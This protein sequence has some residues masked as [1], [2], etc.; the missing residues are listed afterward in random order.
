MTER[1][2][3]ISESLRYLTSDE[4]AWG[5]FVALAKT[6]SPGLRFSEL[7]ESQQEKPEGE[8]RFVV[9]ADNALDQLQSRGLID[10]EEHSPPRYSL[11]H[12]GL[13]TYGVFSSLLRE[14]ELYQP[15]ESRKEAFE[16]LQEALNEGLEV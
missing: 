13:R 8:I 15:T 4:V 10:R 11:N 14:I 1:K 9:K 16:L 2:E 6:E 5:L 3:G 12:K 7:I